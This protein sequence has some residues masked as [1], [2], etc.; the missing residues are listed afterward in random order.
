MKGNGRN[1]MQ[2]FA[3]TACAFL[4][5]ALFIAYNT[6]APNSSRKAEFPGGANIA[7]N[8]SFYA[9]ESKTSE[10]AVQ[11]AQSTSTDNL[12]DTSTVTTTTPPVASTSATTEK[13]TDITTVP[14]TNEITATATAQ[15][16]PATSAI[17][18]AAPTDVNT[19]LVSVREV[20]EKIN[21]NTAT[22][23]ELDT[24][25]GIGEVKAQAIIDYRTEHGFFVNVEELLEVYGI[26]D[27]TFAKIKDLVTV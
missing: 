6:V 26:G 10:P 5:V 20:A 8:T 23:E 21:I 3:F 4:L 11:S 7:D 17:V 16:A 14:A 18:T 13:T 25:P 19:T 27:A 22:K 1:D 2:I 9:D 24:L 15:T 12:I